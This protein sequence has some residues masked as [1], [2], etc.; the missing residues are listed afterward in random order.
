MSP[1]NGKV[2]FSDIYVRKNQGQRWYQRAIILGKGLSFLIVDNYQLKWGIMMIF[3]GVINS[4][5]CNK[6]ELLV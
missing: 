4:S 1:L 6:Y 2:D 3:N 5:L